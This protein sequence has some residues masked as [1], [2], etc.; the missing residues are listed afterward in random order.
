MLTRSARRLIA[1]LGAGSQI[2]INYPASR[3]RPVPATESGGSASHDYSASTDPSGMVQAGQ[4]SCPIQSY[5]AKLMS[6]TLKHGK[7]LKP[8]FAISNLTP[9][10]LLR[11]RLTLSLPSS[12]TNLNDFLHLSARRRL[13]AHQPLVL[14]VQIRC[15]WAGYEMRSIKWKLPMSHY[16]FLRTIM[17]KIRRRV[18]EEVDLALLDLCRS[19]LVVVYTL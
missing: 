13:A 8:L 4:S 10:S 14:A 15:S 16:R 11:Q 12:L 6:R 9:I 1:S 17:I 7:L 5:D 2:R 19:C 3:P 18:V